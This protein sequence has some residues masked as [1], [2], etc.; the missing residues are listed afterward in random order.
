VL[1]G[2]S[3]WTDHRGPGGDSWAAYLHERARLLDF[4]R[5]ERVAGVLLL[6]G[7]M[8]QGQINTIRRS[9]DGAYDLIEFVSSP[10]ATETYTSSYTSPAEPALRPNYSS[11]CNFGHLTFDLTI[12]DPTVTLELINDLGLSVYAPVRIRA[13]QLRNG[14]SI[15]RDLMD[16]RMK[17]QQD[18]R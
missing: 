10:L 17:K 8:H 4:I 12:P 2:G 14:T 16:D 7:D 6:S 11:G 9:N 13:S 18:V 3:G 15:W 1:I 5:D